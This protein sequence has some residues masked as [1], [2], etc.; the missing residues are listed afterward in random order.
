MKVCRFVL[1][2]MF[3]FVLLFAAG[4]AAAW[5]THPQEEPSGQQGQF[6]QNRPPHPPLSPVLMVLDIDRDHEV[7]AAEISNAVGQLLTLDKNG[8]GKLSA[9]ELRPSPPENAPPMED[10]QQNEGEMGQEQGHPPGPP[11]DPIMMLL[12]KN[13]DMELSSDEITGAAEALRT[14]DE[15]GDGT[16][17]QNELRP[18][19]RDSMQNS[20]ERNDRGERR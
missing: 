8:D 18:K 7:S 17:S 2:V 12:D 3:A 5:A 9:D 4:Y 6:D 16:L 1:I 14:M 10:R 15:N 20:G 11:P 13:R 19:G